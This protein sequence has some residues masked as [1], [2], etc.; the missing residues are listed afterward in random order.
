MIS[1]TIFYFLIL[2]RQLLFL[3]SYCRKKV[4]KLRFIAEIRA[5]Y[6]KHFPATNVLSSLIAHFDHAYAQS[7]HRQ[8]Q[9]LHR[10]FS[11]LKS[12]TQRDRCVNPLVTN[13][14][15]CTRQLCWFFGATLLEATEDFESV[16]TNRIPLIAPF[17]MTQLSLTQLGL[18][19]ETS[20]KSRIFVSQFSHCHITKI[21]NMTWT[22]FSINM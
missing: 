8:T 17:S 10:N 20:A 5:F 9:P 18:Q 11:A 2:C 13:G 12:W 7:A 1:K 6:G 14:Y 22:Y 16:L 21:L 15:I 3:E 19:P 4:S